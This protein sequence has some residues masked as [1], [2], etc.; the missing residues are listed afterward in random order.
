RGE[1]QLGRVRRREARLVSAQLHPEG[2]TGP[3]HRLQSRFV[4][5]ILRLARGLL[6]RLAANE[7]GEGAG[8]VGDAWW[9]SWT[10]CSNAT[11]SPPLRQWSPSAPADGPADILAC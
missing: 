5:A 10:G 6:Q 3:L 9:P 11:A 7:A 2:S 1:E 8:R 4:D